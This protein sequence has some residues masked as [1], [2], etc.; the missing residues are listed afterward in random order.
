MVPIMAL[1]PLRNWRHKHGLSLEQVAERLGTRKQTVSRIERGDRDTSADMC[2]RIAAL[3]NYEVTPN[4]M[5][6]AQPAQPA[7][8]EAM[9]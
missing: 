4:D 5:I 1:H 2:R 3:T 9:A 8:A 6:L 7:Q